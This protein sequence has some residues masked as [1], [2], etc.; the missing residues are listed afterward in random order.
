[1]NNT[2]AE[3]RESRFKNHPLPKLPRLRRA[4]TLL[5]C[6]FRAARTKL[7]LTPFLLLSV[8]EAWL[9]TDLEAAYHDAGMASSKVS[10]AEPSV[11][12]ED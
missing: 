11:M 1:M 6:Q 8:G 7:L 10:Y 5:S 3:L 12:D 4:E 9:R 2:D